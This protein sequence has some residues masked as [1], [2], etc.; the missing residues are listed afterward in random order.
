MSKK[1]PHALNLRASDEVRA[2]ANS[3]LAAATTAWDLSQTQEQK[4]KDDARPSTSA[5]S[6]VI[7]YER[8]APKG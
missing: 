7:R 8:K 6:N 3:I 4:A 5:A 1:N 2:P